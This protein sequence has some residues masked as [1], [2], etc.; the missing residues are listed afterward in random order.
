MFLLIISWGLGWSVSKMGLQFISPLWFVAL[1]LLIAVSVTFIFVAMIGKL[2]IPNLQDL[3]LIFVMG[4]FQ[5]AC[6]MAFITLGLEYVPAGRSALLVYTTPLWVMSIAII[7]FNEH[8]TIY[9]SVG[10]LLG[11]MGLFC[12]LS[13][14]GMD[15]SNR[16]ILF[17]NGL[18]LLAALC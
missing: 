17:G 4:I 15:W 6:F 10:L 1:R 18:L 8:L 14:W 9:K 11:M 2:I 16:N 3:P 7:F 5:M 13:P 12:L